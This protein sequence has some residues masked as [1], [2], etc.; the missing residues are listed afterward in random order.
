MGTLKVFCGPRG[1]VGEPDVLYHNN[2]DGTFTDVTQKAG[3]K[4]PNYFGFGVVFSD[5]DND[6][7][8]EIYVANDSVPNCSSRIIATALFKRS[9]WFPAQRSTCSEAASGHGCCRW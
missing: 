7:W 8:P 2:G 1:L 5:F 3:V 9:V 6:G 4:E